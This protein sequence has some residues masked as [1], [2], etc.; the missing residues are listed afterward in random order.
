MHG[1]HDHKLVDNKESVTLVYELCE[2]LI[3]VHQWNVHDS[4]LI[5]IYES[6]ALVIAPRAIKQLCNVL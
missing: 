4:Q 1:Q 6:F 2:E 5:C 3:S